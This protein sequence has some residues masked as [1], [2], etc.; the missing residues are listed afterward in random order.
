MALSIQLLKGAARLA[1][2]KCSWSMV[3]SCFSVF[4]HGGGGD[5]DSGGKSVRVQEGEGSGEVSGGPEG[6]E[7]VPKGSGGT[8]LQV[9][10]PHLTSKASLRLW[11]REP[12]ASHWS[13][14]FWQRVLT[15][16]ES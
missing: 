16:W 1:Y 10:L 13:Q 3:S 5:R 4:W 15:L 8:R 14:I 11:V 7:H 9:T 6:S 2:S 12:R